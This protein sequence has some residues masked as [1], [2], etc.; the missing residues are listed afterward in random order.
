[1]SDE[2]FKALQDMEAAGWGITGGSKL[3]KYE[4]MK[5]ANPPQR[6][7]VRDKVTAIERKWAGHESPCTHRMEDLDALIEAEAIRREQALLDEL[8]QFTAHEQSTYL[9]PR[10]IGDPDFSDGVSQGKN[11][12]YGKLSQFIATKR[13]APKEQ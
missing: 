11:Q 8:L 1:M 2:T 4:Q 13:Q 9:N 6:I 3:P 10:I 12:A 5:E 7:T